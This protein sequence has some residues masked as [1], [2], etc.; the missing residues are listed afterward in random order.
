VEP[1]FASICHAQD[2]DLFTLL[3]LA[4]IDFARTLNNTSTTFYG[5]VGSVLDSLE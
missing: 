5:S 2:P 3:G 1:V 4:R